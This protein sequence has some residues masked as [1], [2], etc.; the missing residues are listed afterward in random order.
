MG[1]A[2]LGGWVKW[3]EDGKFELG[4]E[5]VGP[6]R[7]QDLGWIGGFSQTSV[8]LAGCCRVG[9]GRVGL[10]SV[11]LGWACQVGRLGL[12]E[13][14]VCGLGWVGFTREGRVGLGGVGLGWAGGVSGLALQVAL[15]EHLE[16][17]VGR[18]RRRVEQHGVRHRAA[19]LARADPRRDGRA[20]VRVPVCNTRGRVC[21][22][23]VCVRYACV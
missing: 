22:V 21:E 2:E 15:N 1:G 4:L 20:L 6:G 11:G 18:E 23:C 5:S 17:A 14:L 7:V 13:V 3:V 8:V 9:R 19:R 12:G 10:S 16:A